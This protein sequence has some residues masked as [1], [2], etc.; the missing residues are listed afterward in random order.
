MSF[1]KC[2][3]DVKP[4]QVSEVS[5]MAGIAVQIGQK[6]ELCSCGICNKEISQQREEITLNWRPV[7]AENK[8]LFNIPLACDNITYDQKNITDMLEQL[9]GWS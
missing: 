5:A 8:Q 7:R 9:G 4:W 3:S 1:E 2:A 6:A